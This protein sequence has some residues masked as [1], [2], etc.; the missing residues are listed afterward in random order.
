[1][2]RLTLV[3]LIICALIMLKAAVDLPDWADPGSPASTHLSPDFLNQ[4]YG[5][6]ATPNIV[7]VVLADYRSYDTMFEAVVVFV[8]ALIVMI[9]LR[10]MPRK[11]PKILPPRP[12]REGRDTVLRGA[13]QLIIPLMQIFAL[14]VLGHGHYSPGGG[15][16]GGVIFGASFILL[17]LCYN[18]KFTIDRFKEQAVLVCVAGGVL[19]YASVGAICLAMGWN[20]LGYAGL[21]GILGVSEVMA[22][23]HG[24]LA[25]E[26]GVG[27]TVMS[28]MVSLYYDLASG[29]DLDEGL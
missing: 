22:R 16:Q 23:S 15:F 3:V 7:T 8:A 18:L 2:K 10:H 26:V 20:F 24:I 6:T 25:V 13:A 11:R 19:L 28:V 21:A 1:M 17:A 12:R 29:G 4:G 14:Y 9:V 27:I 5:E